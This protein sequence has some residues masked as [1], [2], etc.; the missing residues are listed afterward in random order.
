MRTCMAI[1]FISFGVTYFL[2]PVLIRLC[3]RWG[4]LDIPRGPRN[5]HEEPVPTMGGV[6][7]Y[8]SFFLPFLLLLFYNNVISQAFL[9][10]REIL[11]GLFVSGSIVFG[12][13]VYDDIKGTRPLVKL[14]FQCLAAA[15]I[16]FFGFKIAVVSNPF[17]QPFEIGIFSLPFTILWIVGVTNAIN[18]IDGIDGLAAGVT[19][20]TSIAILFIAIGM[21]NI[22]TITFASALAGGMLGVLRY[23][24]PPA[25]IFLGDSGSMFLG[26]VLGAVAIH[27][28]QKGATAVALLIPIIVLGL[29]LIDTMLAMVR[30]L[31]RGVPISAGDRQHIHHILVKTGLS[32][33]QVVFWLYGL[34]VLFGIVALFVVV[35]KN[36]LAAGVLGIMFLVAMVL[37]WVQRLGYFNIVK[38][39]QGIKETVQRRRENRYLLALIEVFDF[40]KGNSPTLDELWEQMKVL[41]GKM[42]FSSA[43]MSL[44]TSS[45]REQSGSTRVFNWG[46]VD[47]QGHEMIKVVLPL[48]QS[49]GTLG[50]LLL[51]GGSDERFGRITEM[52]YVIEQLAQHV[53]EAVE[54]ITNVE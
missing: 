31:L 39:Q 13:G 36:Q 22:Y 7:V 42:G 12:I 40:E 8:I 41:F 18:L 14:L 16:Y 46:E 50:S 1:F 20:F 47:D 25:K 19:L 26:F 51:R 49:K 11:I 9:L 10:N 52:D 32:K 3:L 23:N 4:I 38:M 53:A 35:L 6:T 15:I 17:G 43:R 21:G 28:S 5:I 30:R 54:K 34:C 24:F 27:G 2:T 44:E 33:R 48:K 29:P 37:Y 45:S